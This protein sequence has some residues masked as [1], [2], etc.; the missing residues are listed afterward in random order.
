MARRKSQCHGRGSRRWPL[1]SGSPPTPPAPLTPR[2]SPGVNKH[3]WVSLFALVLPICG[4]LP[5]GNQE[6]GAPSAVPDEATSALEHLSL[7]IAVFP[8]IVCNS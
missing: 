5:A 8:Q 7:Q 1:S 4:R 3:L 6:L 2:N